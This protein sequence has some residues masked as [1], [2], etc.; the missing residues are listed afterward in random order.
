LEAEQNKTKTKVIYW[1]VALI[2]I[3]LLNLSPYLGISFP[4]TIDSDETFH[5]LV[6]GFSLVFILFLLGIFGSYK[7]LVYSEIIPTKIISSLFLLLYL[8]IVMAM[9][10]IFFN[11]YIGA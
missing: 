10:Y 3:V 2:P 1:V 5:E 6:L 7:C 9:S 8:L 4:E 11:A